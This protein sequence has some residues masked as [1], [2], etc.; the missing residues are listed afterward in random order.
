MP[1]IIPCVLVC[2]ALLG[3]ACAKKNAVDPVAEANPYRNAIQEKLLPDG[4]I[5]EEVDL[6]NDG[7]PEIFN[8]YRQRAD[9]ERLLVRKDADLNNDGTPDTKSWY[10]D[11]GLLTLEEMDQ[12]FDGRVDLW[13]HYQ[14]TNADKVPER[15][16]SE[17]D[18]DYDGKADIFTFYRDGVPVRKERDTNADGQIDA[19]E[20]FD[21]QGKVVKSGRD[22]DFDGSVDQRD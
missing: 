19:W 6:N 15:V 9:A 13:D 17:R 10:D 14:D 4:L 1:R 2:T 16:S 8:H 5:L 22:T 11:A 21:S 12:D 20:K 3:A 7:R 18:S